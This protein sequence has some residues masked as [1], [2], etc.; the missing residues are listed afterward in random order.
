MSEYEQET[1]LD[2]VV[3]ALR[4]HGL[5]VE[6]H[7]PAGDER[8]GS[9][10]CLT[11]SK[12]RSGHDFMALVKGRLTPESLGAVLAQLRHA[13]GGGR[14]SPLL[15]TPC[16]TAALADRLR[17][18]GQPFADG[19]GNAYL[20]GGGLFV[21]VSGRKLRSRDFAARASRRFPIARLK[22]LF[23]LLCDPQ[24]AAAPYRSIAAAADV[25]LGS[26]PAVVADLQQHGALVVTGK[27]RCL[28]A[29]KRL[30]DEWAQG[31]ALGLRGK[32]LSDRYLARHFDD[33]R[34]WSLN[35]AHARW[36]GE[37]AAALLL[38]EL[39][40]NGRTPGVLTLYGDKLPARLLAEQGIEVAGPAAY[41]HLVELRKPFWGASL[42][43]GDE[44]AATV[45]LAL[46]YA[47]LLA[48]GNARCI[49]AAEMIYN[50]RLAGRFPPH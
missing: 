13:S 16:V 30:L 25:A 12:G 50:M 19:A 11:I 42:L 3:Q 43:A 45:P 10:T 4:G 48:T 14:P 33:W 28:V 46:T 5:T 26:L 40:P 34:A 37:A 23:A 24:L 17:E 2:T 36:G 15:L 29:S 6:V 32:T 22:V 8:Q 49:E 1:L 21:F 27:Q 41:E 7:S 38:G 18:Q 44:A 9:A 31:Y 20:E 39:M 47:D 35:P